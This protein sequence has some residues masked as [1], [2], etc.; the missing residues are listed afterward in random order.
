V[1]GDE[2][3]RE[4]YSSEYSVGAVGSGSNSTGGVPVIDEGNLVPQEVQVEEV[5]EG[6]LANAEPAI[7][8]QE[9]M[10]ELVE[11]ELLETAWG[12][13]CQSPTPE[14]ELM[15]LSVGECITEAWFEE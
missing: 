15:D 9:A 1:Y 12:I 4:I 8:G 3:G 7:N 2:E 13:K 5:V 11:Q 6:S 14:E 10:L